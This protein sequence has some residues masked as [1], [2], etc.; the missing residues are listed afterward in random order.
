MILTKEGKKYLLQLI[1]E[2]RKYNSILEKEWLLYF[3]FC[4]KK[5]NVLY[6]YPSDRVSWKILRE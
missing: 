4:S 2:R 3:K 6:L 5:Q 1:K